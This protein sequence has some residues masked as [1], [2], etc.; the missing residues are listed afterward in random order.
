MTSGE[1]RRCSATN[2]HGEPCKAWAMTPD[3]RCAMHGGLVDP[4]ALGRAGGLA[5]VRV[6]NGLGPEVADDDLRERARS[7]LRDMLDSDDEKTR[8]AAARSLFSYGTTTPPGDG[9]AGALHPAPSL[10][11]DWTTIV[12]KLEAAG[13]LHRG[14]RPADRDLPEITRLR[15]RVD[16]LEAQI[17]KPSADA[18]PRPARGR[19]GRIGRS[20]SNVRCP[21]SSLHPHPRHRSSLICESTEHPPNFLYLDW[22]QAVG[23][24][25]RS[26]FVQPHIAGRVRRR[27]GSVGREQEKTRR[28]P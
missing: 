17:E 5:S 23:R 13:V 3:G 19:Q 20:R 26:Q 16:E 25:R 8:L 10:A 7:R 22:Q 18:S 9:A 27:D 12:D 21:R 24:G 28:A 2:R 6:R 1:R 14:I 4:S 11:H 15:Q